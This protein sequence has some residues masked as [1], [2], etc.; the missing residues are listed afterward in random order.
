[1]N[2]INIQNEIHGKQ[3]FSNFNIINI[4]N[5]VLDNFSVNN[6]EISIIISN[7]EHLRKLKKE[8]FNIDVYTDVISFNLEDKG[9]PIEGE[10]YISW[11]RIND[12]AI[13]YKQSINSELKRILIHGI[14]HLLG[15]KD[16]TTEEKSM[17]SSL[18]DK[19]L[20]INEKLK[21]L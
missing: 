15:Y 4:C 3:A 9:D 14:L 1:M 7:D 11:D 16:K 19:Y 18:E 17:M 2:K 21:L 20:K 5:S 13:H 6:S 12:N 10:I 8:F